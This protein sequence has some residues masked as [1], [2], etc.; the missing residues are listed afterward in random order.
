M[1]GQPLGVYGAAP[2]SATPSAHDVA[3]ESDEAPSEDVPAASPRATSGFGI[4]ALAVGVVLLQQSWKVTGDLSPEGP[5]FLPVAV[6]IGWTFCPRRTSGTV[7][8]TVPG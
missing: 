7:T 1:C 6:G 2:G 3:A 4:A 5:R 8:T